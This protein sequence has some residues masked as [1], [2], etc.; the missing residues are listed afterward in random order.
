MRPS[1]RVAVSNGTLTTSA[2]PASIDFDPLPILV[3][4]SLT[5]ASGQTLTLTTGNLYTTHNGIAD[6]NLIFI[7][8]D[9]QNGFF[10]MPNNQ[11][12]ETVN[13]G[14]ITFPQQQ[15]MDKAVFFSQQGPGLSLPAYRVAVSDGRITTSSASATVTLKQGQ[16]PEVFKLADLNGQNGFKLDGE[17]DG[18]SSGFSV[19]SA[20]DINGDGYD[21]LIIGS[22]EYIGGSNKGRS[23]VVF[24]G[25]GVGSSG[26][27]ALSSL[28]GSNGFKLD[29]E[30]NGDYSGWSVSTAG[31]VNGDGYA[32]LL[33]GA[34]GYPGGNNKGRS[35]L[36]FGGPGVGSAGVFGLSSLN[37]TNGF[38]LDGENNNDYSGGFVNTAGDI[39]GD[40]YNDLLIGASGYPEGYDKGRSYVAFGG[41][42][43]GS[44]GVFSLS[45]LDGIN[46]FKLDGENNNDHSGGS[47]SEAGDI[48]GDGYTDLTLGADFYLGGSNKGRSYVV[49]GDPEIGSSGIIALSSLNGANGF[50]LDGENNGDWSGLAVS[51]AGDI[52]GDG[53]ADLL[54]GAPYHPTGSFKG[55]SYVMF[56]GSGVG[57]AGVL[58]LSSLNG[59]NGFKLNG[60]NDNDYSGASLGAAGDIN[61]DGY[62]DLIIGAYNYPGGNDTGRSYVVFGG[63]GIGGGGLFNL[64]SLNGINGFKLDGENNGDAQRRFCYFSRR[65]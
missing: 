52:N 46:G 16:F 10:T 39:N 65:Y 28:N 26:I 55:R 30:N 45:S 5:I 38:K 22:R 2:Q 44:S 15:V 25:P 41:P 21:D 1:Y 50:K 35:Y 24:G 47:V 60:E 3:R 57:I 19:S 6:P 17:N 29:G 7:I 48:N 51:T 58:S 53:Y 4:N 23:Y 8:T 61:G 63:A 33:I 37:G 12:G 40:G 54:I 27:I 64:S 59:T 34:F 42:G 18:D 11:I 43:V 56:G 20:G 32:D 14:N 62:S 9:V 31:D 49:F 13:Q 36:V